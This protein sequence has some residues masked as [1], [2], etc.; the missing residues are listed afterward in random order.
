MNDR[1]MLGEVARM[2][3]VDAKTLRDWLS[4]AG[5]EPAPDKY[6]ARRKYLT[7][8]Q[9]AQLAALHERTPRHAPTVADLAAHVDELTAKIA[10][11]E[12]AKTTYAPVTRY[13]GQ[14]G[15]SAFER[16]HSAT[17]TP[18]PRRR[19]PP[20]AREAYSELPEGLRSWHDVANAH[21]IPESTMQSAVENGRLP[22]I[23]GSWRIGRHSHTLTHALDAAGLQ[24]FYRLYSP[25]PR[26]KPCPECPHTLDTL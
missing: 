4:K 16:S 9:V 24:A 20:P 10:A 22:V 15:A 2:L 19:T 14:E 26:F 18:Y 25:S 13:E 12:A 11:L 1:H 21:G 8:D 17:Y 3:S 23:A 6:D 7:A 5:I